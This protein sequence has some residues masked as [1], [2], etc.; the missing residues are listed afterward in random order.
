MLAALGAG[1]AGLAGGLATARAATDDAAR[2]S[3][4]GLPDGLGAVSR[5]REAITRPRATIERPRSTARCWYQ[6]GADRPVDIYVNYHDEAYFTVKP[7]EDGPVFSVDSD[8]SDLYGEYTFEAR[9]KDDPDG[10]VLAATS[11]MFEEGDSYTAGIHRVGETEYRLSIYENDFHPSDDSRLEIRHLAYP[12]AFDWRLFPKPEADPRI[13][14]DERSGTLERG[15]WQKAIDVVPNEYRL[16][17]LVDG[18]VVAYRQDLELET[19]RQITCY[20]VGDP[21]A[22]MG[23]DEKEGHIRRDEFQVPVGDDRDD[24]VTPPAAP[25]TTTDDNRTIQFE[26]DPVTMYETNWEAAEVG[27]TDPD[28]IV[29]DMKVDDV[30]PSTDGFKI[31]DETV[32]RAWAIGG[33]TTG[34]LEIR[35]KVSPG[36]YDVRLLA[37][38]S[39][40]G[41]RVTA[42]L[43]VEVKAVDLDRLRDLVTR[44]H[45]RGLIVDEYATDLHGFLDD[46]EAH[47]D[48]GETKAACAALKDVINLVGEYKDEGVDSIAAVDITE[49]TRAL[50]KHLGCG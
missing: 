7:E 23:S 22:W 34:T 10:P 27:A 39:S 38:H 21:K 29:N 43:P 32:D 26:F 49:E 6:N 11:V 2:S 47:L 40:M 50:R 4:G 13:P 8:A 17:I 48:A 18:D 31:P 14:E 20:V 1:V 41:E 15:Q 44:Y 42:T 35:P 19:E 37:N 45:D 25:H 3:S 16:E 9:P 46:A 30:E 33:T 5:P 12:Q 24:V 28:G 36:D